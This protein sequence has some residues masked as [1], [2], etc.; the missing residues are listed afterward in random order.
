MPIERNLQAKGRM[1]AHLNREVAPFLIDDVEVIVVD[2]GPA[3]GP[4]QH[5]FARAIVLGL[6]HQRRSLGHQDEKDALKVRIGRSQFFGLGVFGLVADG[7]VA[8]RDLMLVSVGLHSP[9][10]VARHSA[11]PC[12]CQRRLGIELVPPSQ[13]TATGLAHREI[14]AQRNAIHA[15]I[16]SLEQL[17]D[18]AREIIRCRHESNDTKPAVR[19]RRTSF[20]ERSLGK[21]VYYYPANSSPTAKNLLMVIFLSKSVSTGLH[22]WS[23]SDS[24]IYPLIQRLWLRLRRAVLSVF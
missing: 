22:P 4:A 14:T 11:Q 24:Y 16:R 7:A 8:Q 5:D 13:Q 6:P 2:Q 15:V 10:N 23:N 20:S 3:L 1:A 12:L 9:G 21:S 18:I 19:R 17:S